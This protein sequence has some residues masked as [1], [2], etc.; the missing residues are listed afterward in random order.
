VISLNANLAVCGKGWGNGFSRCLLCL[1][2]LA[3]LGQAEPP[4]GRA[5]RLSD[6]DPSVRAR[7]EQALLKRGDAAVPVCA[8]LAASSSLP[9]QLAAVRVLRRLAQQGH[10][11]PAHHELLNGLQK[12][13][14]A[15]VRAARVALLSRLGPDAVPELEAALTD[16]DRVVRAAALRQLAEAGKP[17]D[18]KACLRLLQVTAPEDPLV[19]VLMRSLIAAAPPADTKP[20]EGILKGSDARL[21]ALAASVLGA[22]RVSSR[23]EMVAQTG[24]SSK[25][26]ELREACFRALARMGEFGFKAVEARAKETEGHTRELAAGALRFFPQSGPT[27]LKLLEED[28]YPRVRQA[29]SRSLQEIERLE[30]RAEFFLPYDATPKQRQEVVARWKAYWERKKSP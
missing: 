19:P 9:S 1:L 23:A 14:N 30:E 2:A 17:F 11:K 5:V 8:R 21:A 4:D 29:A 6:A 24:F 12:S 13:G 22:W 28:P 3:A 10:V 16:P 25:S 7:A 27:L 26:G 15:E 20:V 18:P